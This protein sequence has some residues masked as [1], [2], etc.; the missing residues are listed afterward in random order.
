MTNARAVGEGCV[1]HRKGYHVTATK[2]ARLYMARLC[3]FG[4]FTQPDVIEICPRC[5]GPIFNQSK[6]VVGTTVAGE[7]RKYH[8]RCPQKVAA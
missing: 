8:F 6:N 1:T 7:W 2:W 3:L 4:R 5:S